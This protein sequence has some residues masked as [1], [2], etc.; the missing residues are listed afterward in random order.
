[1]VTRSLSCICLSVA[2]VSTEDPYFLS[3]ISYSMN[4]LKKSIV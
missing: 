3:A 1:M 2:N 4:A